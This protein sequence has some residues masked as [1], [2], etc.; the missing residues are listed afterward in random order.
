MVDIGNPHVFVHASDVSLQGNEV[1]PVP[2][3]EA[4]GEVKMV[5]DD[6]FD[7]ARVFFG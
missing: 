5:G 4:I 3:V 1:V 6:I 2:L 7:I